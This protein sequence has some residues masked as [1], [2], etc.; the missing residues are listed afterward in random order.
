[1]TNCELIEHKGLERSLK[2]TI[3]ASEIDT[4]V[5]HG[6]SNYAANNSWKGFRKGKLP[7][8]LVQ[9]KVG[10]QIRAN[11]LQEVLGPS[12]QAAIEQQSLTLAAQPTVQLLV[13]ERG[14]DLEYEAKFEILPQFEVCDLSK[15]KVKVPT[16]TLPEEAIQNGMDVV[17]KQHMDWQD[18]DGKAQNGHQLTID[19]KGTLNGDVFPGGEA[20]DYAFVLGEGQ[21]LPDFEAPLQ[22]KCT[23]DTL[24][25][26]MTFPKDY[27]TATLA[28]LTVEFEV[29]IKAVKAGTMP[30]LDKAF[31]DKVDVKDG[32]L[33]A[34]KKAVQEPLQEELEAQLLNLKKARLYNMLLKKHRFDLP[35]VLVD[36]E[37]QSMLQNIKQTQRLE[38]A[39]EV[40]KELTEKAEK[41]VLL[42]LV[43]NQLI[44]KFKLEVDNAKLEAFI[45]SKAVPYIEEE[46]FLEWFYSDEA[47]V[48]GAAREVIETQLVDACFEVL[49]TTEETLAYDALRQTI[50]E[51]WNL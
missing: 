40:T 17:M 43:S 4:K 45:K 8:N 16:C 49:S 22:D 20:N 14:K 2:V 28:G 50:E 23:G 38:Q 12:L 30:K 1:M 36:Q 27:H 26:P 34:F 19:F 31:F 7:K 39:P 3:P 35:K 41:R 48:Q 9:S 37:V 15:C 24:V 6:V 32:T 46:K 51:E 33:E 42:S 21:M 5:A 13:D 11:V 18:F 29:K 25:F 10:Q 44:E 47:R